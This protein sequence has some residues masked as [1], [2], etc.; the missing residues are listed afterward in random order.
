MAREEAA[1]EA[2]PLELLGRPPVRHEQVP[3]LLRRD[4]VER[5]PRAVQ[6]VPGRR[7]RRGGRPHERA[8]RVAGRLVRVHLL[9][10]DQHERR[11]HLL[12]H[13]V[14]QQ[15]EAG[16]RVCHHIPVAQLQH[17]QLVQAQQNQKR[18]HRGRAA[19]VQRLPP[20]LQQT[21][22]GQGHQS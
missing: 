5:G 21:Q 19:R 18:G 7:P 12:P 3:V 22:N 16:R 2:D 20:K 17:L 10:R 1:G 8:A 6:A 9:R 14:Q 13:R 4:R 11:P 15:V